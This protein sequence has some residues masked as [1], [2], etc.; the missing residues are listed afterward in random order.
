MCRLQRIHL[1]KTV[2]I[3]V[4]KLVESDIWC[5]AA[6][7]LTRLMHCLITIQHDVFQAASKH[8]GFRQRE[9]QLFLAGRSIAVV[10][11]SGARQRRSGRA[12]DRRRRIV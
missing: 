6:R 8:C 10:W 3:R 12:G 7:C 11:D 9:N 1:E 2:H 4:L 5:E